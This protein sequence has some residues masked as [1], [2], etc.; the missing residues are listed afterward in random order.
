MIGPVMSTTPLRL[1]APRPAARPDGFQP[2]GEPGFVPPTRAQLL[3][4]VAPAF[5]DGW[6]GRWKGTMSVT[7]VPGTDQVGVELEISP[8]PDGRTGWSL[9]YEGQPERA[10]E[11]VP[12]DPARGHYLVDEKNG[13]LL[14]SYFEDGVLLSQFEVGQN[15]VTARYERQGDSLLLEMNVFGKE[16]VRESAMGVRAF[17]LGSL[18]RAVLKRQ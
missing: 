15:R 18:Q 5:P 11:L 8:R 16:P 12:V 7:G 9:R 13:I 17:G 10:Y 1:Q 4:A 3:R 14:D 2:S 6:A